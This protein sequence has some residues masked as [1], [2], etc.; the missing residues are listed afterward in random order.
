[1]M[2]IDNVSTR[3]YN[4]NMTKGIITKCGNSYAIRVPKSYIVDNQLKLGDV[5]DVQ[6]PL[7][8]QREAVDALI[9]HGKKHS[10][11]K[12]IPDPVAWQRKQRNWNDRI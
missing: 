3:K 11:L 7:T 6:D 2:Y 8:K 4:K 9:E 12:E 10:L 5:V 1:M